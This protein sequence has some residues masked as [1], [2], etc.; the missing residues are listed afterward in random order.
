MRS[1]AAGREMGRCVVSRVKGQKEANLEAEQWRQSEHSYRE[2]QRQEI[3]AQWH[4]FF[5][6][7][8]VNHADMAADYQ[9]RAETLRREALQRRGG[10]VLM[11]ICAGITRGGTRCTQSVSWGQ[12]YCHHHDPNRAGERRRATLRAATMRCAN[13]T[14][15]AAVGY[16]GGK[17]NG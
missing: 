3:R 17:T 2:R 12:T 15:A 14:C 5:C 13:T 10:Y 16:A 11:A 7:M 1:P 8:S 9:R 4:A 6:R